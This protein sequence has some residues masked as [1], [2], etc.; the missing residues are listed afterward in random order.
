MWTARRRSARQ[1]AGLVDGGADLGDG[2][3]DFLFRHQ[4]R[5][6]ARRVEDG[7][8]EGVQRQGVGLHRVLRG[9]HRV[10][11]PHHGDGGG[12]V[13]GVAGIAQ[14][15]GNQFRNRLCDREA[16]AGVDQF[17]F[18]HAAP[19]AVGAQHGDVARLQV[20]R[21][22]DVDQRQVG[23]AQAV[24]DLVA[25]GVVRDLHWQHAVLLQEVLDLGVIACARHQLA[26]AHQVH[27]RI[28][29]VRPMQRAALRQRADDGGAWRIRQTI[30]LRIAVDVAVRE[31][32]A[33]VQEVVRIADRRAGV[34]LELARHGLQC[35][36]GRD[37]AQRVSAQA[38][39]QHHQHGIAREAVPHAVLVDASRAFFAFLI[40]RE[41]H[42]GY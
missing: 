28:A 18:L 26:L 1:I 4:P 29:G 2:A 41:S 10:Q 11:L 40:D 9:G 20:S 7:G 12:V 32:D 21:A 34:A 37:L 25:L 19:Q 6:T 22:A 15:A 30:R 33:L 5:L 3:L 31:H 39:A 17:V 23:R 38:I 42:C 13:G 16:R 8:G 35:L 36:L 14:C 27:A 24:V